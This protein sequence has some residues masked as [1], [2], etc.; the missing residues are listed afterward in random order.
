MCFQGSRAWWNVVERSLLEQ[1]E[2]NKYAEVRLDKELLL[3]QILCNFDTVATKLLSRFSQH[4]H[5]LQLLSK[6]LYLLIFT[7]KLYSTFDISSFSWCWGSN[8][9]GINLF[10]S[11]VQ[12]YDLLL[13]KLKQL[14][15]LG[16]WQ[17]SI[18][19]NVAFY[20]F[21]PNRF[22][23]DIFSFCTL[24]FLHYMRTVGIHKWGFLGLFR[25][26]FVWKFVLEHQLQQECWR[27]KLA[28]KF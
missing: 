19:Y 14:H 8:Q 20:C 6:Q 12:I 2:R 9:F 24:A 13:K 17:I 16:R 1:A 5:Q 10:T 4:C 11:S 22:L 25:G 23:S 18:W 28:A 15:C 21:L 3:P 7:S 26:E 27:L